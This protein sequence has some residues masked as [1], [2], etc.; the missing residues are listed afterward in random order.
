MKNRALDNHRDILDIIQNCN[1]CYV[2]MVDKEN[3]PYVIPMNFG[4][5]DNTILLHGAKQGKKIDVL[6]NNPNV[7]IVFSTDHQLHWQNEEV[8]CS[9]S[10]KYRSVIAN[11]KVE[12]IDNIGE[13]EE[14][15]HQ[16][17]KS[18]SSKDFKFSKP[19][20]EEVQLMKVPVDKI[21]GRAYGF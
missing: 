7:C 13:K 2:S 9:W 11:G 1:V 15:F 10:M 12:F 4:F 19:S 20:L 3:K 6:K 17:M 5:A 8:A 16:F 18:Y 14:L 21:E